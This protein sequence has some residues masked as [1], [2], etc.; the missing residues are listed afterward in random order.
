MNLEEIKLRQTR[1]ALMDT[2]ERLEKGISYINILKNNVRD[3]ET[4]YKEDFLNML[5]DIENILNGDE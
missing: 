3:Y 4:E 2:L 5:D 1:L